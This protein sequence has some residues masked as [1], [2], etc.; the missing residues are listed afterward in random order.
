[1][2]DRMFYLIRDAVGIAGS[3]AE[4]VGIIFLVTQFARPKKTVSKAVIKP[5][6]IRPQGQRAA[7]VHTY[8]AQ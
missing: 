3:L 8:D 5:R 6:R 7:N 2:E 1:M 4:V